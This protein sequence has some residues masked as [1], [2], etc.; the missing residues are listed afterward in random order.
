M[1]LQEM[2]DQRLAL[3]NRIQ[4]LQTSEA[5]A[6]ALDEA[7]TEAEQL[8]AD[9]TRRERAEQF[10][11]RMA[12]P[13]PL[14]FKRENP[15]ASRPASTV[16]ATNALD[17]FF[18]A[19]RSQQ[20]F[21]SN[22]AGDVFQEGTAAD[23]GYLV[24]VDRRDLQKLLAPTDMVHSLCDIIYPT[25]SSVQVP[26]DEDPVWSAELAAADTAEGA[27]P[28]EDK[29]A[30]G[31]RDLQL[32]KSM[33]LVRMTREMLEDVTGI[34]EKMTGKLTDK[35][36]WRLH[37]KAVAA[38]RASPAKVTIAKTGGAAV[39][40]APDLANIQAMWTSMLAPMRT[41]A[42]WLAN[43]KMETVLQGFTIGNVPV[44]LPPT[45]I[46]GQPHGRL[47]GRPV[48]FV[49]G[50]PAIGAEGDILLVDP[51]SFWLG[52]KSAGPR[53]EFSTEAE[54]KNDVTVFKG[55]VRSGCLSKFSAPIV[56][57]DA[58]SAGNVVTVATR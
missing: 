1:T 41:K 49:E 14:P 15:T 21:L 46:E 45:G 7:L 26:V 5:D 57:A 38:F 20:S 34:G 52:L 10:T 27:A 55:A 28:T 44:Y 35:L 13:A 8:D 50:L 17:R 47:Y 22:V 31:L 42:V 18:L 19:Q 54:F 36:A 16:T 3:L 11:A 2:R 23:G 39:G 33:N 53:I 12:A 29:H 9:I 30:F 25:G 56:R 40:S 24:P 43:P 4:S 6:A 51:S 37:A 32:S 48:M 58:T